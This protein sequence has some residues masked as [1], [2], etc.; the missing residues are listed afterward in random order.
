MT[1]FI[2]LLMAGGSG[3]R[4][5]PASRKA[6]PKQLLPIGI[7]APLLQKTS[8]RLL[9]LIPPERQLVVTGADLVGAV[10]ELL[11]DVP[12]EQVVGEP[13]HRE[14]WVP[15]EE[16]MAFNRALVGPLRVVRAFRR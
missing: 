1:S 10:R 16:L 6:R 7:D 11:P 9:P 5:W 4:F 2:G 12:P 8:E 13:Q 3:T 15:A 14:L